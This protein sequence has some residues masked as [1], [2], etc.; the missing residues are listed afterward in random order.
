MESLGKLSKRTETYTCKEL[1]YNILYPTVLALVIAIVILVKSGDCE[2]PIQ[3]WLWV[4]AGAHL[5]YALIYSS[6]TLCAIYSEAELSR[7]GKIE[8]SVLSLQFVL[9]LFWFIWVIV[10]SVWLFSSDNC[11]SDWKVGYKMTLTLL[12][13]AYIIFGILFPICICSMCGVFVSS[14]TEEETTA[15]GEDQY[16]LDEP[17]T[18]V[19]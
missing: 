12:I 17:Q 6:F 11:S 2:H 16:L 19:D 8:A 9:V 5:V 14:H 13:K 3:L 1:V 4:L 15:A 18:K 7:L 10:G